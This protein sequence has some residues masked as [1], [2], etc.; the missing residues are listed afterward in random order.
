[1][2]WQWAKAPFRAVLNGVRSRLLSGERLRLGALESTFADHQKELAW[3]A[4]DAEQRT[5]NRLSALE[6]EV[7]ALK[8][9]LG[10]RSGELR[11]SDEALNAAQAALSAAFDQQKRDLDALE[12][13][14]RELDRANEV[15]TLMGW[16][17][18]APLANTPLISV[19]MASRDRSALLP[20]AIASIRAQSYPN[21]ELLIVDDASTDG[22]PEYLASI[23]SDSIRTFRGEGKGPSAARNIA[24]A[25]ARGDFIVYLDDDNIMHP[26]WLK[27][28][29]WAFEN[30]PEFDVLY[31]AFVF[32]NP[33]R[34]GT[35]GV[36]EL[37]YMWYRA[38]D[39][40]SLPT[41]SLADVSA[42]AHRNGLPEG[43]FDETLIGLGDWDLLLRLTRDKPPFQLPAIASYYTTTAPNRL[44]F[45]PT[46]AIERPILREKNRR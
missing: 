16:M 41:E 15:R 40:D 36:G 11:R 42:I 32:D 22:T 13:G 20:R 14:K 31:G 1:M 5:A 2:V 35:P 26:Y 19:I 43:R 23:R 39:H 7:E 46:F 9:E 45:G 37:P 21:W 6:R 27:S 30:W 12:R 17:P 8:K 25:D 33:K 24:L 4:A 38:Y 34:N 29:A 10:Q 44:T 28:V 3:W 18:F